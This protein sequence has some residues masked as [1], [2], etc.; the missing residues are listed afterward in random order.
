M[1]RH[2]WVRLC[3][4]IRHPWLWTTLGESTPCRPAHFQDDMVEKHRSLSKGYSHDSITLKG[5]P[6]ATHMTTHKDLSAASWISRFHTLAFSACTWVGQEALESKM[7]S[8]RSPKLI[9]ISQWDCVNLMLGFESRVEISGSPF[10]T[11][12]TA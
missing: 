3:F 5:I 6:G 2:A 12:P 10:S 1:A 8:C 4:P 7:D 9:S 11:S